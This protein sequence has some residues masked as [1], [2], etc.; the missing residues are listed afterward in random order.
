MML[1]IFY[2]SVVKRIVSFAAI[3]LGN[4]LR[5]VILKVKQ[6]TFLEFIMLRGILHKMKSNTDKPKHSSHFKSARAQTTKG[7][8]S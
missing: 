5:T 7:D 8:P 4:S 2:K 1:Q 3:S 6:M